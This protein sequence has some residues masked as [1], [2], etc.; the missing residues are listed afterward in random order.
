MIVLI[1]PWGIACTVLQA[2]REFK[3][4]GSTH[5]RRKPVGRFSHSTAA[6]LGIFRPFAK[7]APGLILSRVDKRR[8]NKAFRKG[9]I[10]KNVSGETISKTLTQLSLPTRF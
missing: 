5:T 10:V 2:Q 8:C 9:F 4:L 3:S 6:L 7:A 1:F